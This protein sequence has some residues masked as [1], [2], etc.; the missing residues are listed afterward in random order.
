MDFQHSCGCA[1]PSYVRSRVFAPGRHF[2]LDFH[3]PVRSRLRCGLGVPPPAPRPRS[4]DGRPGQSVKENTP[5]F[6]SPAAAFPRFVPGGIQA[7]L[8]VSTD[9]PWIIHTHRRRQRLGAH[10]CPVFNFW[11]VLKPALRKAPTAHPALQSWP[12]DELCLVICPPV[13]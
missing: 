13:S 10:H 7:A 6:K 4:P 8:M 2:H 3:L 11:P 5:M 9:Y 1:T 12:L